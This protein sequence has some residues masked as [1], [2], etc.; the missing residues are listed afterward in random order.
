[1]SDMERFRQALDRLLAD[2]SPAPDLSALDEQEQRM[3]RMAQL[4]RGSTASAPRPE[5]ITHLHDRLAPGRR[6]VSRRGAV[7]SALGTL[8]AGIAAGFGVD[9]A[10]HSS[11]TALREPLVD[12]NGHWMP[13]A[14]LADLPE[15]VIKAFSAGAVQ[16]FLI[17]RGGQVRAL[18]RVCTHMGCLLRFSANE[19]AFVCPCHGAEF[20]LRGD[21]RHGPKEYGQ[22][23]PPLPSIEVRVTDQS[24]EVWTV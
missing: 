1:M 19:P 5:F 3:I 16:G 13:V 20:T 21:L 6:R 12:G 24:I 8:A 2:R 17:H 18:S 15:G 22:T 14:N 7:L 9:Q 23:L 11:P 10:L 4:L